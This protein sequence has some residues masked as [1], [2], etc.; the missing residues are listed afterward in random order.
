MENLENFEPTPMRLHDKLWLKF[1]DRYPRRYQ[2]IAV[3]TA[4][5]SLSALTTY[6][7][8]HDLT[9]EPSY[10]ERLD[11]EYHE[12]QDCLATEPSAA[13]NYMRKAIKDDYAHQIDLQFAFPEYQLD[14]TLQELIDQCREEHPMPKQ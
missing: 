4:A 8:H 5:V 2:R 1:V 7:V 12:F 3:A 13:Q 14:P 9:R 10:A 6:A 11:A